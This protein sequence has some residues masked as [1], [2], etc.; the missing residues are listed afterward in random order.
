MQGGK[1]ISVFCHR[2]ITLANS[3]PAVKPSFRTT[4]NMRKQ[5]CKYAQAE[6]LQ[7]PALCLRMRHFHA[8]ACRFVLVHG[9]ACAWH[10][11]C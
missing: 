1:L 5:I 8:C 11:G 4:A 7:N 6:G 10:R 2:G 3:D 9:C